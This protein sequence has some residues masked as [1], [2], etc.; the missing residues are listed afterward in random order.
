MQ[1][2]LR[3]RVR[4]FVES[5]LQPGIRD[6]EASGNFPWWAAQKIRKEGLFGIPFPREYGGQ[7]KGIM[8]AAIVEEELARASLALASVVGPTYFVGIPLLKYGSEGQK[9]KYLTPLA[10]GEQLAS[11]A[12]T[13]PNAGS[14]AASMET[15]GK[16]SENGFEINGEKKFI[17]NFDVSGVILLF[18]KSERLLREGKPKHKAI[19]AWLVEGSRWPT[20]PA[21]GLAFSE[22]FETMGRRGSRIGRLIM[23]EM[24]L[25]SENLL[26][27]EGE[28]FVPILSS[29]LATERVL[30]TAEALGVAGA[31]LDASLKRA[32]ER[33]QF[34][35]R[36]GEFELPQAMLSDMISQ[37]EAARLLMYQAALMIEKGEDATLEASIAKCYAGEVAL[38]ICNDAVQI[39]GG[40]GYLRVFPVERYLRDIRMATIGAGTTEV[41]KSFIARTLIRRRLGVKLETY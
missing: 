27:A 29:E 7:G 36:I 38:K 17:T 9:Q 39:W 4:Q 41:L 2:D 6:T 18:G 16:R 35:R 1:R 32:V 12:I 28:G 31:A 8:E 33:K 13:E 15:T 40:D 11:I 22:P 3:K 14:D 10:K 34:D 37:L 30:F 5:E 26:G 23:T 19:S 20:G 25:S 21:K 24:R